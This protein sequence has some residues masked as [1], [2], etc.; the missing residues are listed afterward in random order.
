MSVIG[1]LKTRAAR[2]AAGGVIRGPGRAARPRLKGSPDVRHDAFAFAEAGTVLAGRRLFDRPVDAVDVDGRAEQ[3]E[4]D[5]LGP[6]DRHLVERAAVAAN[7]H[8]PRFLV[9]PQVPDHRLALDVRERAI[10]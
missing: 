2:A 4:A 3:L 8:R 6:E 9:E 1:G 7:L 5:R 10:E